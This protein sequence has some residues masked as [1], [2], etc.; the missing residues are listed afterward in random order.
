MKS[1]LPHAT[2]FKPTQPY[3]RIV[4]E[5]FKEFPQPALALLETLLSVNPDDRGT[6]NSAL[7]SEVITVLRQSLISVLMHFSNLKF[8]ILLFSVLFH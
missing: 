3:K 7:Q 4:D 8:M 1:R 2:I 6:A 5:T